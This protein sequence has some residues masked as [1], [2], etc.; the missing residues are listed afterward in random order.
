[1][2]PGSYFLRT[3]AVEMNQAKIIIA[4]DSFKGSLDSRGVAEA[5]AS[6]CRRA[7]PQAEVVTTEMADGGEG[8]ALTVARATGGKMIYV[9]SFD[10]L[11]RPLRASYALT[12]EGTAFVELASASGLTLLTPEERNPLMTTTYGTGLLIAHALESGCR[13][14]VV[15]VGGSAT[16]DCATGMLTALGYSFL[17]ADGQRLPGCG[18]SLEKIESIDSKGSLLHRTGVKLWVA[19]DVDSPFCGETGAARMFA[20]QKGATEDEIERL[21]RGMQHFAAVMALHSGRDI[22]GLPG[23]G[24]AGGVAGGLASLCEAE[25]LPGASLVAEA[26]NLRGLIK[27]ATLVITG[28]GRMDSQTLCGKAPVEV[29]RL[30][31]EAGVPVVGIAGR[32]EDADELRRAGFSG[33]VEI[34]PRTLALSEALDPAVTRRNIN[35][36]LYR[37]LSKSGAACAHAKRHSDFSG[38]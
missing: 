21:D 11:M 6:A 35:F 13:K 30:A 1:M 12:P 27:G 8:T 32:I 16:N 24:A 31:R 34:S 10:P 3:F 38:A 17:D 29:A 26:I 2:L 19:C 20:A 9:D 15:C 23:A 33:L 36:F 4:C 25:L 28:E 5:A 18:R 14:L 22:T 37:Y 7:L